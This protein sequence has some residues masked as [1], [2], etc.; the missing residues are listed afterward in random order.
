M[1]R[2]LKGCFKSKVQGDVY[3]D[4]FT[5]GMYATDASIYQIDPIGVIVPRSIA[6]VAAAMKIAEEEGLSILARG[7]GTSQCGQTVGESIVIDSSKYLDKILEFNLE[8]QTCL[9]EPGLV[10]DHLNAHL[11]SYG[12]WFPVDVST[13]AQATIGG[14]VG[15]NS[16]GSRSIIYG[17]MRDNVK[18][19]NAILANGTKMW[20]GEENEGSSEESEKFNFEA[21]LKS[22]LQTI[23]REER[24][25]VLK[26]F[27]DLMRRVGGYNIDALIPGGPVRGEWSSP[28]VHS[29]LNRQNFAHLLVGSEGTLAYFAAIE[30]KLQPIP[31][32]KAL[33]ICHFS[34]FNQAMAATKSIVKLGP[35][36]VELVDSNMISLA[37]SIPLFKKTIE[38]F[39]KGKPE[40]LLLVEFSEEIQSENISR[41]NNL[42]Q[43]I[44]D[45]GFSR[46]VVKVTR[47][48]EQKAVWSVRKA[49]LNIMMSMRGDG[50]P[51]SFI[52]DCAV[53]LEDLPDYTSRLTE[54]FHKYNTHGTWYAHASVGCLHVR[55]ILNLKQELDI[56]K[57]RNIAEEAFD[58][59]CGYKGSHSGEHGDGLVRS[60]FHERMFGSKLVRSFE[61]IKDTFDPENRMNPGKIVRSPRMDDRSLF[62]FKSDYMIENSGAALDWS[63]WGDFGKAVEMC[64]NNGACR[65]FDSGVMCPSYR[66]TKNE[67]DLTRGRSNA[68]RL[69]LSGQ[70][71]ANALISDGMLDVM[72]LC[73][74]CKGCKRECPTGVDMSRMK[75]EFLYRYNQDKGI[76][77]R[78]R[79]IGYLPRYAPF[80]QKL[81][82]MLNSFDLVPGSKTVIE[83]NLGI[84]RF[85]Q[86]PRWQKAPYRLLPQQ[87]LSSPSDDGK[88]ALLF[89]D[90]F[91]YYFEPENILAAMNVFSSIGYNLR[92]LQPVDNKRPLCCGRTFLS[93]GL[94]D[95]AR[96]E[97]KRLLTALLPYVKKNIP[98]IG[99]E[100]S[101][102]LTLRDE[103]MAVI[104]GENSQIIAQHVKLF[105]EFILDQLGRGNANFKLR[106]LNE[107]KAL[108]HGH[109]HQKAL[110]D[111]NDVKKV[112]KLI[113][114]L[115]VDILD[116]SCCGMAGGFGYQVE[117]YD[118][119]MKMGEIKLFP[120]IRSADVGTIIVADGT[121][122]RHQILHGTNRQ[123]VHVARIL[124]RS[125]EPVATW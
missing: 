87:N 68:L 16:C 92:I 14:M 97:M 62:R 55:P 117:T 34:T 125:I 79:L 29:E 6:D 86:L 28:L 100:P 1:I 110:S 18:R 83:K 113:P 45:L 57:M 99:L 114:D 65:K 7:G 64:N 17:T 81:R 106:P 15:N 109:C 77:L 56:K 23:G 112:L 111:I 33:G 102:L 47:T 82:W 116:V 101:C 72:K 51:I 48:K 9:V 73:V 108:V 39:V 103:L 11:K 93:V 21:E 3:F 22:T 24:E 19:V 90:T 80:A 71:G 41:L 36:A 75:I 5:R 95:E 13:S 43:L 123:A 76:K 84:S 61:K 67:R 120:S 8:K 30:L 89:A 124:E 37:Y 118:E 42:D 44:S 107:T 63:F 2:N 10:L 85:R 88:T 74:S 98:V 50:K 20:F 52:E 96:F 38:T 94:V 12:L 91:S 35:S 59:I 104:P 25:E 58:L 70:L 122:C 78:D 31:R 115:D 66:I 53:R 105:E 49:A 121:S 69:A 46:S 119:S 32:N 26:R 27:P 4:K 60:E 40:A 54:I